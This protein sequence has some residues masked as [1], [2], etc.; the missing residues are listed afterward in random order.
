MLL[1]KVPQVAL[2]FWVIKV[3]ATTVGETAVDW[4]ADNVELG[5]GGTT[6]FMSGL[7][8]AALALQF[9]T[10]SYVPSVYWLTVVLISI[11]GTLITDNLTDRLGVS[12]AVSTTVF[13]AALA[14]TF[15][16]W[17]RVERTLSI[18]DI[19]TT[20]R[21]AFS[22][23]AILFTF[24]L[25]TAAGDWLAEGLD[26]G[27]LTSLVVFAAAIGLVAIAH[28]RL[29]LGPVVAFWMAYILTRPLGASTGD[30]LS[31]PRADGG[32]GLGTTVTSYLFLAAI[33]LV[34]TSLSIHEHRHTRP[35]PLTSTGAV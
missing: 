31:Q 1:S 18:H 34:V 35:P 12:L 27:Y 21:E 25:G 13:A 23:P 11:V 28:F 20:R 15:T 3:L 4:L 30:F 2:A 8:V 6:W 5:L 14:V 24:A 29:G 33:L 10:R 16:I 7:L 17:Y 22:W 32:L 19:D 26:L 9:R